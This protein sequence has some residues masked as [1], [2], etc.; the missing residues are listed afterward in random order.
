MHIFCLFY[1]FERGEGGL[2]I[3]MVIYCY[4]QQKQ[5]SRSQCAVMHADTGL[6]F[7]DKLIMQ[8]FLFINELIKVTSPSLIC[9]YSYFVQPRI[10][11]TV[12]LILN[13]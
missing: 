8:P 4:H 10:N 5:S 2:F 3:R 1:F 6:P 12:C 9:V 11:V 7:I 13:L